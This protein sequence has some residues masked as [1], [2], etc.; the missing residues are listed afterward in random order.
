MGTLKRRRSAVKKILYVSLNPSVYEVYRELERGFVVHA[1]L[2]W[3][4]S[5]AVFALTKLFPNSKFSSLLR[6]R[7][8]KNEEMKSFGLGAFH[9]IGSLLQRYQI[10]GANTRAF[11]FIE[12]LALFKLNRKIRKYD[13]AI[14]PS[15]FAYGLR[16]PRNCK[17]WLEIRWH[18]IILNQNRPSIKLGYPISNSKWTWEDHF[19]KIYNELAGCIVYSDL[20]KESFVSAGYVDRKFEVVRLNFKSLAKG[21]V[22]GK[23]SLSQGRI[24]YV[25]RDPI[26]KGL[27][28]AVE[29][30]LEIG[31]DL[32]VVGAFG[33][34]VDD[35]LSR[36]PNV[37]NLGVISREELHD[38]F[39]I[40]L[41]VICPSIESYGLTILEALSLNTPVVTTRFAGATEIL[42]SHE[43]LYLADSLR[44]E[45]LRSTSL[46]CLSTDLNDRNYENSLQDEVRKEVS[47]SW[48]K[49]VREN[50]TH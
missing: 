15:D 39:G 50:L 30:S 16:I 1:M 25:G 26:D 5:R 31:C 35:W 22:G 41:F 44:L 4:P 6:S 48:Q 42:K 19:T 24:I 9:F 17:V 49:F 21:M 43:L 20:V 11:E 2:P 13:Y 7:G 8:L 46:R 40:C 37:S 38:L 33:K 34:K 28:L 12:S 32:I 45:D 14:I 18:H 3:Q 10:I 27:D 36:F 23:Y 29:L 47:A